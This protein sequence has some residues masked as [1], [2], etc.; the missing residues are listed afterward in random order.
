LARAIAIVLLPKPLGPAKSHAPEV[1][2]LQ[3]AERIFL[4]RSKPMK[5]AMRVG[6][7]FGTT[8]GTL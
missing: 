4:G 7:Y 6:R 5:S 1:G 3:N 8:S 2:R